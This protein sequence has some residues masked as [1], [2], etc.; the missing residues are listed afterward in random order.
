MKQI[1]TAF[2]FAFIF[3]FSTMEQANAD[4][5]SNTSTF[6][7]TSSGVDPA[8]SA[9]KNIGITPFNPT[10]GTLNEVRISINGQTHVDFGALVNCYGLGCAPYTVVITI[11][12]L[13]IGGGGKYFAFDSPAG[14]GWTSTASSSFWSYDNIFTY[15]FV[16]ND[17]T[18]LT[19]TTIPT[20]T[21]TASTYGTPPSIRGYLADFA[22]FPID[23]ITFVESSQVGAVTPIMKFDVATN[24]SMTIEYDYTP[25]TAAVPEPASMLLLGFGL[26]GLAGARRFRK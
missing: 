12:N 23:L 21:N 2:L 17:V 3:S 1:L 14:Y 4:L 26:A 16:F 25:S 6:S 11:N 20:I 19:G 10:Q 15:N 18:D 8:L 22:A 13:L 5:I 9:G 7:V 24:G